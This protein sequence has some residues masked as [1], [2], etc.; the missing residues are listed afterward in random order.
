MAT[1]RR[2]GDKW[3]AE[4]SVNGKRRSKRFPAAGRS[5]TAPLAAKEWASQMESDLHNAGNV[6]YGHTLKQAFE[7]YA[8]EVAIMHKGER[9]ETVRLKKLGRDKM[10]NVTLSL[11]N[12][13]DLHDWRDRSLQEV[14]PASVNREMTII[15]AVVRQCIKWNWLHEY[16]FTGV[17]RPAQPKARSRRVSDKEVELMCEAVGMTLAMPKAEQKVQRV[18]IAFMIAIETGMR[19]GEICGLTPAD[20]TLKGR[21]ARLHENE[22]KNGDA[23]DVPLSSRAVE[24]FGILLMKPDSTIIGTSSGSASTLFRRIRKRAGIEGLHFHDSRH[25]ACTRL[26]GK[27][28]VLQLA[29]IIGHRDINSLLIYYNPTALELAE[30][31]G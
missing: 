12:L 1:Y 23:R 20:V 7:R 29:R 11:L 31:I 5:K 15:I 16:P 17:E 21:A 2:V 19:L 6:D 27:V 25:E 28:E 18:I 13:D 30:Q 26:S 9:W 14:S 10:A 24:L 8:E 3:R 4:V 22:T